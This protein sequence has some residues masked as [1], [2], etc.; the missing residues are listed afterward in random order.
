VR[1]GS[2]AEKELVHAITPLSPP[3]PRIRF[4]RLTHSEKRFLRAMA[5]MGPG[6]HRTG[7]IAQILGVKVMSL[8]PVRAKLIK[9]GMI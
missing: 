2:G 6:A 4:D 8:G 5:E 1:L 9:K 3:F 7:N